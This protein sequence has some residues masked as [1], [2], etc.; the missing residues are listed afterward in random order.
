M[1]MLIKTLMEIVKNFVFQSPPKIRF[2]MVKPKRQI[3]FKNRILQKALPLRRF[4]CRHGSNFG[5]ST[6]RR[7]LDKKILDFFSYKRNGFFIEAGAADGILESNTLLLEKKYGWTG[8]LVE[9]GREQFKYC[10]KF[11]K[12][13]VENYFL[14]SFSNSS[15]TT[16]MREAQLNSRKVEHNLNSS[17]VYNH[18]NKELIN[19]TKTKTFFAKNT[20]LQS[21]LKKHSI[22]HVDMAIIDVEGDC[23]EVLDGYDHNSKI[24]NFLL[25]EVWKEDFESFKR[26][27]EEKQWKYLDKWSTS[28]YLFKL[29]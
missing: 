3:T 7:N 11:R 12:S 4:L 5:I 2:E 1:A 6:S 26:K 25:V 17:S 22:D 27:A 16:L 10:K 23:L 20:N 28:D 21:L 15:S 19:H 9:P 18:W 8:L 13:I 24:I 14:T 29:K